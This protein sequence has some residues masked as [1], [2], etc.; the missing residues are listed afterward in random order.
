M[1]KFAVGQIVDNAT[2]DHESGTVVD[3]NGQYHGN[4]GPN[5]SVARRSL[6]LLRDVFLLGVAV[7][8]DLVGLDHLAGEVY[9]HAVLILGAG[10]PEVDKQL[11]DRVLG[12]AGHSNR[13]ADAVALDQASDDLGTLPC[14]EAIHLDIL[15]VS[16]RT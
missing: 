6:E 7:A 14:G 8:P 4:E 16:G 13:G 1:S 10:I 5:V 9:Q 15:C 12:R 11:R 2:D 3:L